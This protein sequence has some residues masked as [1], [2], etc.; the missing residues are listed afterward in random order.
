M[1]TDNLI[2]NEIFYSIQG[3]STFSGIPTVFIRLTGCPLRCQYCDTSY[4]FTEGIKMTF[5]EI[6]NEVN[7]YNCDFI[8]VTGGEPLA[9]KNTNNLLNKLVK[10]FNVS[11]ETSNALSIKDVN[12]NV[13][14]VLDIKTPGSGEVD[15][16]LTDNYEYLT[17][18]HQL[19]FVI[20]NNSDYVWSKNY[21]YEYELHKRCEILFS[22]SNEEMNIKVL[23][24]KILED[25]IPARLQVQLH[26]IIWN[27]Q[28]GK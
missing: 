25:H 2:I 6:L 18:N 10:K 16:N 14:I 12:K 9:Q 1:K 23:A 13:N 27:D 26:K 5:N 7:K 24:E 19:K 28:R 17:K 21:I 11:L 4:A 8:T 15:K 3:E 22:P 20:C